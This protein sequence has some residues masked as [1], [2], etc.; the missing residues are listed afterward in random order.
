[1]STAE[2]GSEVLF[3]REDGI[4][5]LRLH[6]PA[7]SLAYRAAFAGVYQ[8]VFNEPPYNERFYPSEAEAVLR[9]HLETPD[10]VVL[11]AVRGFS[12]VVG[13][14]LAVPVAARAD[15]TR[16]LRGLLPIRHT[17]YL[18]ELGILPRYRK[19]GLGRQ[20]V[21]L[22]L[23]LIEASRFDHVV[24]RTSAN[25]DGAYNM[26]MSLGFEDMGAYMEVKSRR[27]DGS[28]SSDRRLFLTRTSR[29]ASAGPDEDPVSFDE[30]TTDSET[31]AGD[32]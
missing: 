3:E 32:L 18:S 7:A 2:S 8:T 26:F 24:L 16:E 29:L 11:L 6:E 13:F 25:R 5:I 20:L 22:R 12:Q 31:W 23:S 27:V 30:D 21:Q 28:V 17:M 15:V 9:T 19:S 10:H 4:R 14:G 1:M